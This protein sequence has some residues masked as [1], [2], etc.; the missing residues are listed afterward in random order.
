MPTPLTALVLKS[1]GHKISA[2]DVEREI[3]GLD[4]VSEVMVTGVED[5]EFGQRVTA[6]IVLKDVVSVAFKERID[7]VL[8]RLGSGKTYPTGAPRGSTIQADRI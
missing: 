8:N 5:E 7:I 4:Y 1:G 6:A 2:L 3:L